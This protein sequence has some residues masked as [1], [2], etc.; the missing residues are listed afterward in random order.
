MSIELLNML[1]SEGPT[2]SP[3]SFD[4][5]QGILSKPVAFLSFIMSL[6]DRYN[7]GGLNA[8]KEDA[9]VVRR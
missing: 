5:L 2:I 8:L 7:V 6:A 9:K 3:A 4:S 1:V